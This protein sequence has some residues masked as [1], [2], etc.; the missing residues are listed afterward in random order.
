MCFGS[1]V[2]YNLKVTFEETI[3]S[4]LEVGRVKLPAFAHRST[5]PDSEVDKTTTGEE[6]WKFYRSGDFWI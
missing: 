6:S 4:K 2:D 3:G 5:K 1:F